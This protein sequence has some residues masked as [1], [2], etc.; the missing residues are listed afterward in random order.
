MGNNS[1]PH[2]QQVQG[3]SQPYAPHTAQFGGKVEQQ[4]MAYGVFGSGTEERGDFLW[5]SQGAEASREKSTFAQGSVNFPSFCG[6]IGVMAVLGESEVVNITT[7]ATLRPLWEQ[8]D[9][10]VQDDAS[11]FL[12]ELVR[13][14][15]S[16][17]VIKQYHHVDHRQE[18][19]PREA[20]P[21]RLIYPDNEGQ[22]FETLIAKWANTA[23]GQV[24]AGAGL[25][26]AQIGRYTHHKG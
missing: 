19:H 20:F 5:A 17:A 1:H 4:C 7:L 26:V 12:Q 2:R 3:D 22:E 6:G 14:S 23:E 25:W 16:N 24:L 15:D 18:V 13:L 9:D 11:H 10:M 8:F 21:T